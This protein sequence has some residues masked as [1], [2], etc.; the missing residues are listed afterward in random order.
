MDDN[1]FKDVVYLG[2]PKVI[3]RLYTKFQPSSLSGSGQE[4][5]G[6]GGWVV[7]LRPIL[8]LSF[9]FSQAEQLD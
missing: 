7:V 4:V 6:D 3:L 8:V 5:C 2:H 9:C 1:F